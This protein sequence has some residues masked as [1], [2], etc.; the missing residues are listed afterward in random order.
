M[1]TKY[2][3]YQNQ[4]A[5]HFDQVLKGEAVTLSNKD[6]IKFVKK[7]IVPQEGGLYSNKIGKLVDDNVDLSEYS[8]SP[9]CGHYVG[10][11]WEGKECPICHQIVKNNYDTLFDKNGWINIGTHKVI[12]PAA[13]A[14]IKDLIGPS[15]LDDII[16]FNDNIDLQGNLLIGTSE[17][18]KKHPFS[19]IGMTEFYK[20]Y[21]EI[22]AYYGRIK[23]KPREAEFLIHFK[24]RIWTSKINVLSQELRPAFIN[25]AEK[26]MRYD[27]INST[28]SVIIN[29]ASLIA[30]SEITNQYMN[31]NKYLYTI[32]QS[33]YSLYDM[34]I[35]K[36]DG[37]KKLLRRNIQGTKMSWSSRLVIAANTGETYGIDQIVISYKAFLELYKYEIINCLKRGVTTNA[38]VDRTI[39]EITEWMDIERYSHELNPVLYETM[40]WLIANNKDG[41]WCLVNRPPT[42]DLGSLQMLRVVDVIPNARENHMK[43]PLTSLIAWNGDF[44]GDTLSLYSIKE[45]GVCEAFRKAFSPRHLIVDKVSGYKVYNDAFG[46]PKDLCM[47]LFGF[48]PQESHN[49]RNPE[50]KKEA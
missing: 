28:Y 19:K 41:L 25:S 15:T 31:I 38:F 30:K 21:E 27:K 32:Q 46:L 10:R 26:T 9:N 48:V 35:Q 24:N 11:I 34:I 8:C 49:F 5:I 1:G 42:M 2:L 18:D 16:S 29:N 14:K 22:I 13:Y 44:D 6:G 4:E 47:F 7:K 45:L 33:L 12:Q 37:K 36:L 20:R 43:V 39:Y 3:R 17:F 50:L 40:K 23:R